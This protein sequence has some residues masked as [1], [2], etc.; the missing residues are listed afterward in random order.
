MGILYRD[1]AEVGEGAGP[2]ATIAVLTE[3]SRP[4][5]SA[6]GQTFSIW[7]VSDL[8]G[9]AATTSTAASALAVEEA[10]FHLM[11][12]KY[13]QPFSQHIRTQRL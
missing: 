1:R 4:R 11:L 3:K 13:L 9:D 6:T 2:W 10:C 12:K 5:Q 8:A 7:K